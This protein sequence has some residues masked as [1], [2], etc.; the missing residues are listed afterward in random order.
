MGTHTDTGMVSLPGVTESEITHVDLDAHVGES[1]VLLAF[2]PSNFGPTSGQSATLLRACEQ[3]ASGDDVVAFGVAPES[4]YSHRRFA[5]EAGVSIPLLS[6]METRAAQA[7]DVLDT[8]RE[9]PA[10]PNRALFVLDYRGAV[11]YEWRDD[12]E[13]SLP[14]VRALQDRIA[15]ITPQRSAWSCYRVGYAHHVE[16]RRHLSRGFA[17]CDGGEWAIGQTAFE[18]AC[19]EFSEATE[20]FID[21]KRLGEG[22]RTGELNDQG[23]VRAR[24]L[25]EAAEWLAGFALAAAN[26]NVQQK[27]QHRREAA[28]VLDLVREDSD[29]PNPKSLREQE[30][31]APRA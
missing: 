23:R 18:D 28:R 5:Y 1:V 30:T 15:A 13:G 11:A 20:I 27:R 2:Y 22:T 7:Y 3:L 4:V 10:V 6:D 24:K 25:W 26:G 8:E 9:G 29:L 19:S 12:T 16:G 31:S 14:D 21:G 17:E